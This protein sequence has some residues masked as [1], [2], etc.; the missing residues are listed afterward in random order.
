MSKP[1]SEKQI[2]A[3]IAALKKIKPTIRPRSIFGDNHHHA[4]EAQIYVLEKKLRESQVIDRYAPDESNE[5]N[6]N[7][8]NIYDAAMSVVRWRDGGEEERP[9]DEWKEL[10]IK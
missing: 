3:E 1:K 5:E 8:Q 9:V 6:E 4:V 7:P 10:V 2:T